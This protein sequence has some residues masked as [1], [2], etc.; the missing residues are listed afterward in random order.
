MQSSAI[1]AAS[2]IAERA[3][4]A[5]RWNYLGTVGRIAAQ[6]VSQIVLARLLGPEPTG[7]FACAFLVVTLC[8][9]FVELGLAAG[10]VQAP[11]L[12]D[13]QIGTASARLLLMGAVTSAAVYWSADAIASGVFQTPQAGAVIRAMAPT[14]LLSAAALPASALLRRELEFGLVQGAE[15]GSYVFGY[16]IVGIACATFGLGVWSLVFAWYAQSAS[17]CV[18][19]YLFARKRPW[20]GNPLRPLSISRFGAVIMTTNLLNWMIDLSTHVAAGRF[21]GAAAL[22]QFTM[23]NNLVR[24]PA[25]HLVVS[26]QSVLFPMAARAQNNDAGLRR[27]YL[28]ALAGVGLIAFPVFAFVAVMAEPIVL[29][30]LGRKWAQAAPVLAAL[31]VA[32]IPHTAMAICGP[33]L[34]GRGEPELELRL[35]AVTLVLLGVVLAVTSHWTLAAMAWGTALVYLC[36]CLLMTLMLIRRLRITRVDLAQNLRGPWLLTAITVAAAV[37]VAWV[38]GVVHTAPAPGTVLALAAGCA[39]TLI[40][41]ML[42]VAPRMVLG[43]Q[44]LALVNLLLKSRP[45]VASWPGLRRIARVARAAAG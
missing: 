21:F 31:S 41:L 35:Q 23:S 37:G 10:L 43:P 19:L 45:A 4:S 30:L 11:Q 25:N 27:A 34:N 14:L 18:A 22:G 7:V 16:L 39:G 32:M 5:V 17:C 9:L 42:T 13:R 38:L 20:P 29:L 26:L 40:A 44:M 15:V 33:L 8:V 3:L 2:G 28:S 36:R 12:D 6:F 1:N 24:T